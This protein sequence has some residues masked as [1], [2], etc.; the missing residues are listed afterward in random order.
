MEQCHYTYVTQFTPAQ[1]EVCEENFEKVC[2][3][4]F[5]QQAYNETLEKCYTPVEKICNGEGPEE[6]RTVYESSCTTRYLEKSPGKFVADTACEK[7]PTELCGAGCSYEEGP[8]EC[9]DKVITT[10]TDVPEEVCDLNPQKTCHYATKL[11]PKLKPTH[12]CTIVPKET[13][14]LKFSAPRQV[15]K[16]LVTKW[17]LDPSEPAPGDTYEEEAAYAPVLGSG[18]APRSYGVPPPPAPPGSGYS[19]P[20]QEPAPVYRA[21]QQNNRRKNRRKKARKSRRGKSR[22]LQG[23]QNYLSPTTTGYEDYTEEARSAGEEYSGPVQPAVQAAR[24]FS[25]PSSSQLA[26]QYTQPPAAGPPQ[27]Y[28]APADQASSYDAPASSYDAPAGSYDAPVGSYDAPAGSYDAPAASYDAPPGSYDAPA[29]SYDAPSGPPDS[30]ASPAADPPS[31]YDAPR[32]PANTYGAPPPDQEQP[33]PAQPSR[34]R[35]PAYGARSE[36]TIDYGGQRPGG[37]YTAPAQLPFYAP[38]K[39]FRRNKSLKMVHKPFTRFSAPRSMF[40][41]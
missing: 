20:A 18:S 36:V 9:H 39:T 5:K 26:A 30:Y 32:A 1:E 24:E 25:V 10:V 33:P 2:S 35:G 14:T 12:E 16:P 11:V 28:D 27:A 3:I 37:D 21:Q 4:T 8:E 22:A 19:A 38:R 40:H 41:G 6:C 34:G 13:C 15:Q 31:G 17:C 7:L 29:G 23:S